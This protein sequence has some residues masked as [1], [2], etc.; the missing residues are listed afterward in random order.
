MVILDL[1]TFLATAHHQHFEIRVE[2]AQRQVRVG[3]DTPLDNEQSGMRCKRRTADPEYCQAPL[4]AP[5]M[6]DVAQD[7]GVRTWRDG[8]EETPS[9][10]AAPIADTGA[11]EQR[12]RSGDC[13]RAIEQD[14][15]EVWVSLEN[16]NEQ[17]AFAS[18]NIDDCAQS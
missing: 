4:V 9:N 3:G 2:H 5:I 17:L 15:P 16:C 13:R 7:V 18:A 14:A 6:E 11:R 8:L 1:C 12:T 10:Y